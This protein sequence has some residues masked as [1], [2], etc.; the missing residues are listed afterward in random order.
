MSPSPQTLL[1]RYAQAVT[2]GLAP[3]LDQHYDA[4][5]LLRAAPLLQVAA[6]AFDRA[7]QWRWQ[8]NLALRELLGGALPL[9][10]ERDAALANTLRQALDAEA[11]AYRAQVAEALRVSVL[12]AHN[13]TLRELLV[14]LHRW[15]DE[16]TPDAAIESLR[17]NIWAELRQSTIRR[18]GALDRF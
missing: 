8:E 17:D 18:R 11:A 10:R 12:S 1:Q 5:Q 2:E 7:A 16:Q 3:M 15:V 14:K 4:S 9:L 6:D 13:T